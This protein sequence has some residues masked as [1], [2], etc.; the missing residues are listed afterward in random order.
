MGEFSFHPG[1]GLTVV[2]PP[3]RIVLAGAG[4]GQLELVGVDGDHPAGGAGGAAIAQWADAAGDAEP[5]PAAAVDLAGGF[6]SDS[7]PHL[8]AR[9]GPTVPGAELVPA[10]SGPTSRR[11]GGVG[12][13]H[14]GPDHGLAAGAREQGVVCPSWRRRREPRLRSATRALLGGANPR[15]RSEASTPSGGAETRSKMG[16]KLVLE[17]MA[18]WADGGGDACRAG[19]RAGLQV[20][21]EAVF[22]ESA[23][24]RGGV[25][26]FDHRSEPVGLQPGEVGAGAVGAVTVDLAATATATATTGGVLVV[27]VV[28]VIEIGRASCRER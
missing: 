25:L 4:G 2:G 17:I 22:A 19:D 3:G 13:G 23:A 8:R 16:P 20:D 24:R 1:A 7:W 10:S 15:S 11:A 9:F 5:R 28:I 14:G 26:G 6:E 12:R 21:A 18:G 27:V